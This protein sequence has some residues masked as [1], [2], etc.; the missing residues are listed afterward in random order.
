V[1]TDKRARQRAARE[2][3]QAVIQKSRKRRRNTRR[4]LGLAVVAAAIIG[5]V[6][7]VNGSSS[8]SATT[9]TTTSTTTS[10]TLATTTTSTTV[11][12]G[13]PRCPPAAGSAERVILFEGAPGNCIPATSV[14]DATFKTSLGDIV[15]NM[16]AA[17]SYAA[18]NNF[19]FLARYHY[20]DGTI[21]HRVI[22]GFVVQGGDPYGDGTGGPHHFPGYSFTGNTPPA[23]CKTKPTSA[24]YQP[25]DI[26]MANSTGPST[27]GSQ[28][29]F[30]LP[31]GQTTL[32]TEPNYTL[33]GHVVQGTS[34]MDKIGADGSSSGTPTVKVDLI[35]VTVT[36]VAG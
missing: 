36:Q 22:P 10:T 1:P 35:S 21:F 3:K 7:W 19:V 11:K 18:V 5:I 28:F 27:N 4:G 32:D 30:V 33:F 29:F 15:V 6:F 31:G 13:V 25:G 23:S 8:K 14:W 2:Q 26:A 17:S 34:V 9:T 12:A 16:P 20:Y 24:C